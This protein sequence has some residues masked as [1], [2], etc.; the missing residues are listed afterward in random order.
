MVELRQPRWG[1]EG[2]GRLWS[3]SSAPLGGSSAPAARPRVDRIYL[4]VLLLSFPGYPL[5]AAFGELTGLPSSTLALA[6]R[7]VNF[8]LALLLILI[9]FAVRRERSAG[10]ILM[11]L[12]LFWLAY[13]IRM[14]VDTLYDPQFLGQD[15]YIYWFW[16]VGGCLIPMT[17]LALRSNRPQQADG[18]FR[19]LYL[20]A[21]F[22]CFMMMFIGGAETV[23]DAGV[24]V[25]V[26]RMALESLNPISL[27]HLAAMLLIMSAWALMFHSRWSRGWGRAL[28]IAGIPISAYVLIAANSRGPLVAVFICLLFLLFFVNFR[29]KFTVLILL[30]VGV[31][32]VVPLATFLEESQNINAF[33]RLFDQTLDQQAEQ[34]MRLTLF[35]SAFDLFLASPWFGAAL[36]DPSTRVYPHNVVVEAFMALG[37]F[38]GALF[39]AL[40]V[41]LS[42]RAVFLFRKFPQFGWP[43]LLF[44]QYLIGAQ[45]S[46]SLYASTYLW[47][48]IG[49]ITSFIV[50]PSEK[51]PTGVRGRAAYTPRRRLSL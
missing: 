49:L 25:N 20:A 15:A 12:T 36:E 13:I 24:V 10:V 38:F 18:Y 2:A 6:M 45:F 29:Y 43:S 3:H 11:G 31:V 14:Y 44:I 35:Q 23:N 19:W 48:A 46:G 51:V 26:G 32:T 37:L 22:T 34:S 40:I 4:A 30:A 41:A 9:G 47:C 27:G 50:G 17:G 39:V 42:F 5:V 21:F 7:A 28:P 16:G 8:S 1:Q 33:S